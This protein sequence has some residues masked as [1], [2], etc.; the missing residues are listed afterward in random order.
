[1]R[2]GKELPLTPLQFFMEIDRFE[3]N[4]LEEILTLNPTGL[5]P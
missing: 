1:V 3:C 2:D 5:Q 4:L